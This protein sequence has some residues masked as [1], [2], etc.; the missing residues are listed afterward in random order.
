ML[1]GLIIYSTINKDKYSDKSVR[2]ADKIKHGEISKLIAQFIDILCVGFLI[3]FAMNYFNVLNSKNI[4][5]LITICIILIP[6]YYFYTMLNGDK[7]EKSDKSNI[8]YYILLFIDGV[9]CFG[10]FNNKYQ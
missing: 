2:I 9:L 8:W 5:L 3:L 6:V 1:L 10:A 7:I 4:I